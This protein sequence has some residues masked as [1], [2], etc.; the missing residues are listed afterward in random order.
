MT[1]HIF[2]FAGSAPGTAFPSVGDGSELQRVSRATQALSAGT[3][4]LCRA[5]D[6]VSLLDAMCRVIV[7]NGG[8]ALAWVGYAVEDSATAIRPVACAGYHAGFFD[9]GA[10]RANDRCGQGAGGASGPALRSTVERRESSAANPGLVSCCNEMSPRALAAICTFPLHVDDNVIGHLVIVSA[11]TEAFSDDEESVLAELAS[12]LGSG[13]AN[14]RRCD[15]KRKSGPAIDSKTRFDDLT[16]LPN[17]AGLAECLAAAI[18][19]GQER[20][21]PLALLLINFGKAHEVNEIL[22]YRQGDQLLVELVRRVAAIVADDQVLARVGD[23]SFALLL[24]EAS[25]DSARLLAQRLVAA[26]DE[27]QEVAGFMVDTR[28]CIGIAVF[29]RHGTDADE[30]LRR[31]SI[32]MHQARR[33]ALGYRPSLTA[34]TLV[35]GRSRLIALVVPD[36]LNPF[37]AS[38]A[39]FPSAVAANGSF[40]VA[41]DTQIL[42]I[43]AFGAWWP[44]VVLQ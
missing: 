25:V 11:D 3:R 36:L 39:A 30:L 23:T 28:A 42:Y 34:Q 5:R 6:E 33:E 22:G 38:V 13:I 35:T 40:A 4:A 27:P 8:Y 20:R 24:P 14:L 43:A 44:I 12:D 19:D 31:A 7:E 2:Q 26:L 10:F 16:G 15:G 17:R 18:A 41:N 37:Y 32:A 29:P 9:G 21:R 1:E